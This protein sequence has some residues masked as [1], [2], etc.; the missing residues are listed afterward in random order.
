MC[1]VLTTMTLTVE[2]HAANQ[3]P[4]LEPPTQACER[5]IKAAEHATNIPMNLLSA[6]GL[7][8]SGRRD[9]RTGAWHPWPWTIDAEGRAYFYD[10]RAE[11]ITAVQNWQ[12]RGVKSIDVGCMQVNLMDHPDAFPSLEAAFDPTANATY[13]SRLLRSL[14]ARTRDWTRAAASYHSA[15]PGIAHP[16]VQKVLMVLRGHKNLG[17]PSPI[18]PVEAMATAWKATLSGGATPSQELTSSQDATPLRESRRALMVASA[19]QERFRH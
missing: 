2:C 4:S 17:A 16:Y 3:K 9:A 19:A 8:E 15:T 5:A 7:V 11:A 10:T 1:A 14:F 6:I 18:S 12:A 13:A